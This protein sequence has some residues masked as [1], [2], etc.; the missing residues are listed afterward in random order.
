MK[1]LT[2]ISGKGGTGKTTF[3]ANLAFLADNV[4]MADCDVD[5]PN[6]HLL[7]APEIIES[8][9][10][11]GAKLAVKNKRLCIDC[12]KCREICNFNAID[13]DNEIKE[14]KCEGCGLC[15]VLCPENALKLAKRKTGEIFYSNS[16]SG[17]MVHARLKIGA[18]NSGKLVSRV[19][20]EAENWAEKEEHDLLVIDGSPGV[21]CPVIASLGGADGALIVTE[22]SKS[23]ISDMERIIE[24]V[25]HFS[26]PAY[27]VINKYDI[28]IEL[29]HYIADYCEDKNIPLW[30]KVPFDESVVKAMEKGELIV[31]Y[32]PESRAA[33]SL[34]EIWKLI[35][36]AFLKDHSSQS[37]SQNK[38]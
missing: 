17:P 30:G 37:L 28:N 34:K 24:V 13:A 12:G 11:R 6:M 16:L 18:E 10:Y 36:N 20:D 3:A 19:K 25:K 23:G 33:K 27:M 14:F 29:T 5:A 32:A 15:V 35:N 31:E 9:S 21:G 22:P 7:M 8:E 38:A 26:I 1:K 2:V 4:V